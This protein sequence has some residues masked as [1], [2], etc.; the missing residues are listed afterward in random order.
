MFSVNK[1]SVA[2][3]A[4]VLMACVQPVAAEVVVSVCVYG[5]LGLVGVVAI[6]ILAC[7]GYK[8]F[9]NRPWSN[10]NVATVRKNIL[11]VKNI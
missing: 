3:S 5:G 4:I 9:G 8:P 1:M 2:L 7:Q 6:L 10:S 11:N